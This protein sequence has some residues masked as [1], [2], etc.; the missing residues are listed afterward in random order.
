[1]FLILGRIGLT[2]IFLWIIIYLIAG[3]SNH[4]WIEIFIWA[5]IFSFIE[6]MNQFMQIFS[7]DPGFIVIVSLISTMIA[8]ILL[9][10]LL[11]YRLKIQEQVTKLKIAGIFVGTKLAFGLLL[12]L[13]HPAG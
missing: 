10:F 11:D 9:Y 3:I 1:M 7:A 12:K 2:T 5:L 6:S 4:R 8:G 13:I